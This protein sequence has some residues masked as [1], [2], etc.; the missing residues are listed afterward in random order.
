MIRPSRYVE[1]GQMA[2]AD[3]RKPPV[4]VG[5]PRPVHVAFQTASRGNAALMLQR[6]ATWRPEACEVCNSITAGACPPVQDLVVV[7]GRRGVANPTGTTSSHTSLFGPTPV[8]HPAA[9]SPSP[10]DGTV[11]RPSPPEL[12]A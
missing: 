4:G 8:L 7:R 11:C 9:I 10:G 12:S 2:E 5:P 1:Y 6:L 3:Q